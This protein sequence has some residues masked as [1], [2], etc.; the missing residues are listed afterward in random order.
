MQS[1]GRTCDGVGPHNAWTNG[2]P[3]PTDQ[4]NPGG[5]ASSAAPPGFDVFDLQVEDARVGL[6]REGDAVTVIEQRRCRA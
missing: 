3:R 1:G 4:K 2:A 5:A 6:L